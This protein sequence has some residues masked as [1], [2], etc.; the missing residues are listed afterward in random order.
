MEWLRI[1]IHTPR[2]EQ[3]R[4]VN[5]EPMGHLFQSTL[6]MWG[7]ASWDAILMVVVSHFNPRSHCGEQQNFLFVFAYIGKTF[8]SPLP[9]W[10]VAVPCQSM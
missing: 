1:S 4:L 5:V 9:R 2:G 10:G 7:A 3:P 8:Q 6:L